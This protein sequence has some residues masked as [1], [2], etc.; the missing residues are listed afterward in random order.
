MRSAVFIVLNSFSL[1]A[2]GNSQFYG[3]TSAAPFGCRAGDGKLAGERSSHLCG[4]SCGW[5]GCLCSG[6]QPGNSRTCTASFCGPAP[7]GPRGARLRGSPLEGK[8]C[9]VSAFPVS[10]PSDAGG[11]RRGHYRSSTARTWS[12]RGKS[13]ERGAWPTSAGGCRNRTRSICGGCEGRTDVDEFNM[14]RAV[15]QNHSLL[16]PRIGVVLNFVIP[17]VAFVSCFHRVQLPCSFFSIIVQFRHSRLLFFKASIN[18]VG[19]Q[20]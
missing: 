17:S 9:G 15:F 3:N 19:V 4:R 20:S 10:I 13:W 1:F 18:C 6:R 16:L 11:G 7:R 12:L 2:N 5:P 8:R 14:T